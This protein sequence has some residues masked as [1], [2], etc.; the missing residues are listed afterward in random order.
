MNT[1]NEY[2]P[3]QQ[4]PLPHPDHL[5]LDDVFVMREAITRIDADMAEQ[6]RNVVQ[7]QKPLAER[8]HRQ[9][10]R[11]LHGFGF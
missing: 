11:V 4:Y 8:V 9:Q 3:N 5:L 1:I 10:L 7:I 2:T 6:A